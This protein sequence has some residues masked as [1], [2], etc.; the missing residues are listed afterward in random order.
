MRES[1]ERVWVLYLDLVCLDHNGN[2][3][4][5]SVRA[6]MAALQD[7]KLP[8]VTFD[9]DTSELSCSKSEKKNLNLERKPCSNSFAIFANSTDPTC[10]YVV[11]DPT[12]EEEELSNS[13]LS[14]VTIDQNM[15]HVVCPGGDLLTPTI[16]QTAI[17]LAIGGEKIG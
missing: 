10:P 5:T 12:D 13:V 9:T 14:I 1:G 17:S 8:K 11:M 2:I 3:F 16:L 7:T 4:D 6:M 15:C